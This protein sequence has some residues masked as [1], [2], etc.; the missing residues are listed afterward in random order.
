V[1]DA[2][3]FDV[4]A[5]DGSAR[6]TWSIPDLREALRAYLIADSALIAL[7]GGAARIRPGWRPQGEAVPAIT[8]QVE[9]SQRA[10]VLV[11]TA[12]F[13]TSAVEL[14]CWA[15]TAAQAVLLKRRVEDLLDVFVGSWSGLIVSS[16]AQ[17]DESDG[18]VWPDDGTDLPFE[19]VRVL[20]QIRHQTRTRA[21]AG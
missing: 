15:Q 20:Y 6:S 19:R 2:V 17:D 4:W 13:T 12:G 9:T 5:W 16:C 8:Y 1:F 3:A 7:C 14:V 11:S 18:H 10:R 21:S